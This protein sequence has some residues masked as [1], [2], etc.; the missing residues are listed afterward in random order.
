MRNWLLQVGRALT[1]LLNALTGG[2][3]DTT[4]SA[5]SW[6]LKQKGAVLGHIR[7]WL[8]DRINREPGHCKTAWEWHRQRGLI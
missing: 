7:V 5:R 1:R 4:F 3:G 6:H 2:T 8:V